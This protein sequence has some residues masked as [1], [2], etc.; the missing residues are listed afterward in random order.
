MVLFKVEEKKCKLILFNHFSSR[1]T[2]Q[3]NMRMREK[4]YLNR[5]EGYLLPQ[6]SHE[7]PITLGLSGGSAELPLTVLLGFEL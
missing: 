1:L 7:R 2:I 4:E 3:V 5:K 6:L